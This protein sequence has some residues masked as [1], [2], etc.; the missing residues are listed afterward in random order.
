MF[1]RVAT[2]SPIAMTTSSVLYS[3]QL[4]WAACQVTNALNPAYP[5]V[6]EDAG[7]CQLTGFSAALCGRWH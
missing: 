7:C 6:D 5:P 4:L 2:E 1:A 3:P